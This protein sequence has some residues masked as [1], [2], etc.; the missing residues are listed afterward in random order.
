[1]KTLQELEF[2][3]VFHAMPV[4][5]LVLKANFT[6]I[7]ASDLYLQLTRTTNQQLLGKYLFD[8]FPDNAATG[9]HGAKILK[10]SLQKMLKTLKADSLGVVVYEVWNPDLNKFEKRYWSTVNS[11]IVKNGEVTHIIHKAE[12]VT[13]LLG[14][15]EHMRGLEFKIATQAAEIKDANIRLQ[16]EKDTLENRVEERTEELTRTSEQLEFIADSIPIHLNQYDSSERFIFVNKATQ[17][18]WG[19]PAKDFIGK[20]LREVIGDEK[21]AD[22]RPFVE[23]VFKGENVIQETFFKNK[24]GRFFYFIN[25]FIPHFDSQGKVDSFINIGMDMTEQVV[26]REKLIESEKRFRELADSMPQIVWTANPDGYVDYYNQRWYD[27]TGLPPGSA[28]NDLWNQVIHPE[29]KESLFSEWDKALKSGIVY[30]LEFRIKKA[31][32]NEY[33][34][35]LSRAVP[36]KDNKGIIIKWYGTNTNIHEQKQIVR[37]LEIERDLRERFVSALTHDLRTP[38][39]AA[40]MAAQ[41]LA[42]KLSQDPDFQKFAIRVTDNIDR[43]DSMI[44]DLLDANLVKAGEKLPVKIS[45]SNLDRI[46]SNA[47]EELSTLHGDRFIYNKQGSFDGFWDPGAM[48]RITENLINNAIK[49]G[50][51]GSPIT[52]NLTEAHDRVILSVHNKGSYI[53]PEVQSGLF[54]QFKRAEEAK[55]GEQRG[56]GIGLS[57]VKG[58]V[59]AHHGLIKVESD[60]QSGTTFIVELP[61]DA[62]PEAT[63]F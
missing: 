38:L 27:F 36:V 45:S 56:W 47:L 24:Q 34:W 55:K 18:W 63:P 1:M 28:G 6:I 35:F 51:S 14:N 31:A 53:P 62:R 26:A 29:D 40:R 20:T 58:L 57:L 22:F 13:D 23:R 15:V 5:F 10:H 42:R 3:T 7:F 41:L 44:R 52:I 16:E 17:D 50:S 43:A 60:P 39:T 4:P 32:T 25:E 46:V 21:Y 48:R 11:P 8:A 12:D 30:E 33:Q 49:Y 19:M 9:A 54:E 61:L 2:S 59:E 37:S